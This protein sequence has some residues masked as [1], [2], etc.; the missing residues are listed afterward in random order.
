MIDYIEITTGIP[1]RDVLGQTLPR[2]NGQDRWNITRTS[3]K[4][5]PGSG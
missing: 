1:G 4:H 5:F 2:S 3:A